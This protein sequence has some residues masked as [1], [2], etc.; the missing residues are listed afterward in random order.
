MK[1]DGLEWTAG[2]GVPQGGALGPLQFSFLII[3]I[4]SEEQLYLSH[5]EIT[6][7]IFLGSHANFK[8]CVHL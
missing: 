8:T 5:K 4:V 6:V 2:G 1:T 7:D 3:V